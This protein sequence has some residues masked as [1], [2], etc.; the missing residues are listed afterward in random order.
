MLL[1]FIGGMYM[2]KEAIILAATKH[3]EDLDAALM[4]HFDVVVS[5]PLPQLET[6]VAMRKL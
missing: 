6:C 1:R 5:F 4:S 3:E 2:A